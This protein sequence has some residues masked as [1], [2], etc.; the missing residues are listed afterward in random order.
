MIEGGRV[1]FAFK[2]GASL[3]LDAR[4][5]EK[6]W[7]RFVEWLKLFEVPMRDIAMVAL[8][9]AGCGNVLTSNNGDSDV[10]RRD[11]DLG[12]GD[13]SSDDAALVGRDAEGRPDS[14]HGAWDAAEAAHGDG[15]ATAGR[16]DGGESNRDAG[17]DAWDGAWFS[18]LCEDLHLK[19]LAAFE[20]LIAADQTCDTDTDCMAIG[21]PGV[22]FGGCGSVSLNT[23]GASTVIDAGAQLCTEYNSRGCPPP[24]IV[25]PAAP[26]AVCDSGTCT[27]GPYP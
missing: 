2:G 21:W 5:W 6:W 23:S 17:E 1:A 13:V 14:S 20:Q 10:A 15:D 22:C 7:V 9:V 26:P 12:G 27:F 19:A 16:T 8:L 18:P 4:A 24:N 3:A 25:C 11:A